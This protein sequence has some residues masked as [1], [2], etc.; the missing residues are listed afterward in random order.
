M[1]TLSSRIKERRRIMGLKADDVAQQIGI[2]RA[3][4]YRYESS[5][6]DKIPANILEKLAKIL[7]TTREYLMGMEDERNEWLKSNAIPVSEIRKI[8]II[9]TV[10]AGSGGI[11]YEEDLGTEYVETSQLK[12]HN[13]DEFFWLKVKGDSMEPRL[14]ENDLVLVRKQSSVDSG[15][16]AVVLVD[17]EEGV[18]KKVVYDDSSITLYSQNHN[19]PP[20]KFENEEVLRVRIVGQ[21]IKSQCKF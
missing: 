9:G 8:N 4:L 5:E 21:V 3:T 10:R 15:T 17:G 2:S 11:T 12:G 20:R 6:N 13:P 7:G 14:F 18:V 16:Y 19:Y 1:A